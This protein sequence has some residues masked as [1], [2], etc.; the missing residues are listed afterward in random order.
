MIERLFMTKAEIAKV[1]LRSN[2]IDNLSKGEIKKML[3]MK[4][5]NISNISILTALL[6]TMTGVYPHLKKACL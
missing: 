3:M 5:K 6:A 2:P 1:R 4:P